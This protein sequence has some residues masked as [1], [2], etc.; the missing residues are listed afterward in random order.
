MTK[1]TKYINLSLSSRMDDQLQE[2]SEFLGMNRQETIRSII[3]D[4]YG[5]SFRRVK[6]GTQKGMA[7]TSTEKKKSRGE[8]IADMRLMNDDDLSS[9]IAALPGGDTYI[10]NDP[11][12]PQL[13]GPED[14]WQ[15][16]TMCTLPDGRRFLY[17][18]TRDK[19]DERNAVIIDSGPSLSLED[20][21]EELK[22]SKSI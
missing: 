19:Q 7:Y 17:V 11:L 16:Q 2:I 3:S 13:S 5:G 12:D 10:Y 9:F 22:K 21:I 20:L 18:E 8:I 6:Y 15:K 1:K 4:F 14:K